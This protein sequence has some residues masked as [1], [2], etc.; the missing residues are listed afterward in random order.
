MSGVLGRRGSDYIGVGVGAVIVDEAGYVLLLR[1]NAEPEAGYWTI[2]GA[3][4]EW[5]E[6]CEAAIRRE[7]SE[8]IGV[9]IDVGAILTVVDYILEAKGMHWVSVE[10]RVRIAQG[11]AINAN[12][13]END[14]IGWFPID[15]LPEKL[16]YPTRCALDAYRTVDCVS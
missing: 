12:Q 11:E 3:A 5:F 16:T 10:Y 8:E 14:A 2:P 6:T 4:V 9:S 13:A 15:A 7:C 1:R